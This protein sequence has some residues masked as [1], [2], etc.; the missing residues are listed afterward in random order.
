MMFVLKTAAAVEVAP[1]VE[2]KDI[3]NDMSE[4]FGEGPVYLEGFASNLT[5]C[6]DDW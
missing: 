6:L 3:M 2:V 1:K 5:Q 4:H